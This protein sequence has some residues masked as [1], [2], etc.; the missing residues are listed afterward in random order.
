MSGAEGFD[1]GGLN[2]LAVDLARASGT[3]GAIVS[4][5]VRKTASDVEATA[6]QF[7]P[8]DTGNLRASIGTD[9]SGDGRFGAVE[10]EIGPTASSGGYVEF[11]TSRQAPAAYMGPA[12]DRHSADFETALGKSVEDLL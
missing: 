9:I 3:V 5:V 1:L 11:G 10:A 12:L 2:S 6:K 8:V 7:C 4:V